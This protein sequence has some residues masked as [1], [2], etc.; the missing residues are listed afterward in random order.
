MGSEDLKRYLGLMN[1][2]KPSFLRGYPSALKEFADF[3][4]DRGLVVP[5]L[6]GILTTSEKLYP[7]VRRRVEDVFHTRIFDGY[8]ANDGGVSAHERECGNLHIDTERSIMEIVDKD[9]NQIENGTGRVLAT[10]LTNFAMPLL[11]YELGDEVIATDEVCSCGRGLPMLKEII[12]RTVAVLVTPS[13]SLIHG[14]FLHHNW[15]FGEKVKQY[16]IVQE[17]I[18]TVRIY[19]VPGPGFG[20]DIVRRIRTLVNASC[21][22]WNLEVNIVESIP[23]SRSGKVIFIESKVKVDGS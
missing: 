23:K 1:S 9:N 21:S 5:R 3:I 2:W 20:P 22:E 18:R 11:R 19:L 15:E 10:S 13:G 12:G 16:K 8:G 4:E 6:K 17:S 7:R 14:W